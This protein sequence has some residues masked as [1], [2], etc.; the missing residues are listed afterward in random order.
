ML[1]KKRKLLIVWLLILA[2]PFLSAVVLA[3]SVT[4]KHGSRKLQPSWTT[5]VSNFR[6]VLLSE[7]TKY[8]LAS[9]FITSTVLCLTSAIIT[10][11]AALPIAFTL[12]TRWRK[13]L[14]AAT[15]VVIG[16]RVVPITAAIPIFEYL[17]RFLHISGNWSFVTGLY[18]LLLLPLACALLAAAPWPQLTINLKLLAMDAPLSVGSAVLQVF[19]A[20]GPDLRITGGAVFLLAWCD[21]VIASFFLPAGDSTISRL[22]ANKQSFLGTEWGPLGAAIILSALPVLVVAIVISKA[23]KVRVRLSHEQS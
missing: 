11:T 23:V 4:A 19:R 20:L 12:G 22:L 10:V 3:I 8:E 7:N 13:H 15:G 5:M 1:W 9:C 14:W 18:T 17:E 6:L 21:F 2:V 16:A